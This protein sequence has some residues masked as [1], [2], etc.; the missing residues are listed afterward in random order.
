MTALR[1]SPGKYQ[2]ERIAGFWRITDPQGGLVGREY[3]CRTNA[4]SACHRLQLQADRKHKR[5]PRACLCCARTFDSEGIHNRMCPACRQ[6][7]A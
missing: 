5:G 6:R 7:T 4:E 1:K 2:V 3:A